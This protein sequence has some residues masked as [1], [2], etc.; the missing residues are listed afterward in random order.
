[1]GRGL[2]APLLL[3]AASATALAAGSTTGPVASI[4]LT[5]EDRLPVVFLQVAGEG[6]IRFLVASGTAETAIDRR[7]VER[8]GLKSRGS[9]WLGREGGA[10]SYEG[11]RVLLPSL[12]IGELVL[13]DVA[14]VSLDFSKILGSED[15]PEGMLGY[16][17]FSG[18]AWTLD[19]AEGQLRVESE[20]LPA[21]DGEEILEV[22][23]DA[24]G[25]P[26][27]TIRVA[28]QEMESH[29]A[30]SGFGGLVLHT[31]QM[32]RLPMTSEPG[33][34]GRTA[35]AQGTF[36][37]YG[38]TLD[39]R[40]EIGDHVVDR[41]R[42]LFSEMDEVANLGP[43]ALQDFAVTFDLDHRRI[44][45]VGKESRRVQLLNERAAS[46]VAFD[47]SGELRDLFNRD[48]DKVRLVLILAPT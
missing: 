43:A 14:A 27:I 41:P 8:L 33:R 45:F 34:I 25:S 5:M 36:D 30:T 21:A 40:L 42:V 15:G 24:D 32:D 1:M 48:P 10:D 17:V 18:R 16:G 29:V 44:R 11:E 39:G 13:E 4:P 9:A 12:R 22:A 37:L 6:P 31:E 20:L 38:G 7:L 46:I 19:F 47:G 26:L 28:G 35:N 23:I 3:L 2:L